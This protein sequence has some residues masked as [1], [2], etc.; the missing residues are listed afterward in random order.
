MSRKYEERLQ[1]PVLNLERAAGSRKN[2]CLYH[3]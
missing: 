2:I 3:Q 1:S